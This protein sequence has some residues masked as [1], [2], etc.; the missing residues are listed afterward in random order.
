MEEGR[1][2]VSAEEALAEARQRIEDEHR[3]RTP[4]SRAL[5]ERARSYL[6]G[7][8][9]R[10]GTTF[11]PYPTYMDH[12]ECV[13]LYD[14]DGNSIL[15]F[16]NN[17]TSLIHGHAHPA[18][19]RAKQQQAARGTAWHAPNELQLHLAQML[20]ERVPSL[21]RVRFCNSGTEANMLAI[22]AARAFT[23]RDRILKVGAAFPRALRGNGVQSR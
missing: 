6:P 23:G 15:D 20:C 10:H 11:P 12:G 8:D 14:I 9:T 19:V 4:R 13:Y 17:A 18:I 7:G 1:E 3:R 5:Q 16:T 2:M 22:K 21:E